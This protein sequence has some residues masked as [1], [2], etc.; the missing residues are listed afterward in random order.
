MY[1]PRIIW[2]NFLSG[3]IRTVVDKIKVVDILQNKRLRYM[4]RIY[5]MLCPICY[6]LYHLKNVT[7][8][9]EE[10]YLACNFTKSNTPPWV[11]LT[12]FKLYKWY[13][14]AQSL[15]VK[16]DWKNTRETLVNPYFLEMS[17]H[18]W[19]LCKCL[20]MVNLW[21]TVTN[22]FRKRRLSRCNFKALIWT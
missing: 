3:D 13:Q 8:T 22:K 9:I 17:A 1:V 10:C 20:A 21:L 11:F 15:M 7:N 2:L 5:L 14:I 16:F 19:K 4:C 12:F 6:H 18:F